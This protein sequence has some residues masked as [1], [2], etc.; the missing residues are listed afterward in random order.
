[1]KYKFL[2]INLLFSG[3]MLSQSIKSVT[4]E[5]FKNII[6]SK[7]VIL[8]DVRSESEFTQGHIPKAIHIDVN[9]D[10]FEK[11]IKKIAK[12]NKQL[13]LYC[14]SGRRSKIAA[15]KLSNLGIQIY[16]LNNGYTE[17]QKSGYAT[18]SNGGK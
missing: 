8:I 16:D 15:S 4:S 7:S 18:S 14:R 13:A 6:S 17:W 11:E 9:G 1:M 5:E 10:D 2:I 3:V 12:K